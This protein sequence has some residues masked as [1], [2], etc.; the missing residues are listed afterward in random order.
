MIDPE[1]AYWETVAEN[2]NPHGHPRPI[3][4]YRLLPG[5]IYDARDYIAFCLKCSKT[6]DALALIHSDRERKA[7][8][9]FVPD[10]TQ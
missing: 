5:E 9:S 6:P 4:L 3:C 8:L 1:L 2:Y 7:G 10:A